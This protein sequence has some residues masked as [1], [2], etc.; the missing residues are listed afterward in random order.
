MEAQHPKLFKL[1]GRCRDAAYLLLREP[2]QG[3]LEA[4]Q[5]RER[6]QRCR[7]PEKCIAAAFAHIRRKRERTS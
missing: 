5:A 7:R 4:P 2:Q 6:L 1:C 3:G